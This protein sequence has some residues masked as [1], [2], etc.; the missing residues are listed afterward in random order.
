MPDEDGAHADALGAR[1]LVIGAVADV[2]AVRRLDPEALGDK[3]EDLRIG[4]HVAAD[5]REHL[6][7]EEARE[8]CVGPERRHLLCAGAD[9]AQTKP[10]AAQ[11]LQRRKDTVARH[12]RAPRK[13][14]PRRDMPLDLRVRHAQSTEGALER[15]GLAEPVGLLPERLEAILVGPRACRQ[16]LAERVRLLDRPV[17]KGVPE[18]ED[19]RAHSRSTSHARRTS[20]SVVR[21]LPI[22]SR[23]TYRP[24]S[25]V[26][27]MK[28]SPPALTRSRSSSLAA[29]D[30]SCLKHTSEK[31]RGAQ[32]SH[33]GSSSTQPSKSDARRTPSRMTS[34]TPSRP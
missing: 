21:A 26:C 10:A 13:G 32:S 24:S 8:R 33:L 28:I 14:M 2:E 15:T 3:Q 23:R 9:H 1:E 34:W 11:L 27:E 30:P 18:V 20:A 29:S 7:V 19:H 31:R 16:I 25:F 12:E 4:F 17:H 5:G 22:A 6:R